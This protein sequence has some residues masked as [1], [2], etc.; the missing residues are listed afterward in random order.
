MSV[1]KER[2]YEGI[3]YNPEKNY[4]YEVTVKLQL[5]LLVVT[6]KNSLEA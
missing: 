5:L 1:Y 6:L 3:S 2:I 4:P